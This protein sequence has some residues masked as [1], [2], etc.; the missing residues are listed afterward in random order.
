M[1]N[2]EPLAAALDYAQTF[3][4]ESGRRVLADLRRKF[5]PGRCC[6]RTKPGRPLDPLEAALIDGQNRVMKE[7]QAALE[8]AKA[9]L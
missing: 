9:D 4:T 8:A 2:N 5:P 3:S 6:F 1:K 7:I